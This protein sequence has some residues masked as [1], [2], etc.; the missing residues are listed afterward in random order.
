MGKKTTVYLLLAILATT[1]LLLLVCPGHL[2]GSYFEGFRPLV[3]GLLLIFFHILGR[4]DK[5]TY[6]LKTDYL[7]VAGLGALLFLILMFTSGLILGFAKNPMEIGTF[8]A[9]VSNSYSYMGVALI[10]EYLRGRIMTLV[11]GKKRYVI[12]AFMAA[13]I[14]FTL[15]SVD[16]IKSVVDYGAAAMLD[17]IFTILLP[18]LVLNT[19]FCYTARKG[20]MIGN[21]IYVSVY[22][23]IYLYSP[24]MPDIMKIMEAIYIHAIVLIM[25]ILYSKQ[26]WRQYQIETKQST[27]TKRDWLW[28]TPTGIVLTL[29]LLFGLGVFPYIPV[30]VASNSMK[31]EFSRGDMLIIEKVTEKSIKTIEAGDIIQYRYGKISVVHRVVEVRTTPSGGKEYVTKGDNNPVEDIFPVKPNQ[32]VGFARWHVPYLG[33]PA[34]L[35]ASLTP[36]GET[37]D[38][39]LGER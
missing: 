11:I 19:F 9:L 15:S 20:G 30:G 22:W 28:M 31:D 27:K 4:K 26:E 36:T 6:S 32:I 29:T 8:K 1:Q 37:G 17:Y 10:R 18:L 12:G 3:Y 7:V 24:I 33:F 39:Q 14:V 25:F 21:M 35:V 2:M 38:I 16:N 34:M 13:S 5:R 23:A